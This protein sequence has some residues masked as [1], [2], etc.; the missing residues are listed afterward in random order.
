MKTEFEFILNNYNNGSKLVDSS[1]MLYKIL[2]KRLPDEIKNY[3]NIKNV[4]VKGSMGNGNKSLIPWI[5]IMN[6]KITKSTQ[7][8]LYIVFLFKA[9]M[10]GFYLSLNQGITY[11]SNQFKGNKYLVAGESCDYFRKK[12]NNQSFS[13]KPINLTA[14]LYKESLGYGYERTNIISKYYSKETI[15]EQ[16]LKNDL[17]EIYKIYECIF[18]SVDDNEY[19]KI[20]HSLKS[21]IKK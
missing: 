1:T 13:D 18:N 10:S 14:G 4:K 2:T 19:K 15:D 8:G 3:L 9:D 12:I 11:L 20:I 17:S 7:F 6:E 21:A 16:N 5:A